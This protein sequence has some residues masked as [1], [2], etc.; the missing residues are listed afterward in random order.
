MLSEEVK[1]LERENIDLR[2]KLDYLE[3][4]YVTRAEMPKDCEHCQNFIQHYVLCGIKYV[5]TYDG[6][7]AASRRIKSVKTDSTCRSFVEKKYGKNCI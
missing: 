3:K 7:C 5:P 4:K 6:S 1:R 2:E